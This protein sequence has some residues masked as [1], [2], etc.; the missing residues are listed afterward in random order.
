MTDREQCGRVAT[1]T[2]LL[3]TVQVL[4][5]AL[6]SITGFGKI[7]WYKQALWNQALREVPW[8]SAVPRGLLVFIGVCEF[9]GGVGLLVPAIAGVKP[10][11]TPIAAIGLTLTMIFAAVFHIARGEYNFLLINVVLGAVSAF[12]AYGRL[13]VRPIAPAS[14]ST[15]RVL[16]GLAVLGALVLVDF[17]PVWYRLTHLAK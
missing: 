2:I 13:F 10:K 5:G 14:I 17:A 8:V 12:I 6:F 4:W 1:M 15:L 9:L 16:K 11:L 7:F 3:W